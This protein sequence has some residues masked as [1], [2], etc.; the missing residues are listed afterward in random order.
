MLMIGSIPCLA[1]IAFMNADS[2]THCL[3]IMAQQNNPKYIKRDRLRKLRSQ[4]CIIWLCSS[5]AS[6]HTSD[7]LNGHKVFFCMDA[8][9]LVLRGWSAHFHQ[10][11]PVPAAK[12]YGNAFPQGLAIQAT[13]E[14]IAS[15]SVY[16]LKRSET[17]SLLRSLY[18]HLQT[19]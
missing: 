6:H 13:N 4:T 5:H 14:A 8:L 2:N 15:S 17:K 11:L 16:L 19:Y 9:F 1:L 7:P 3:A 12:L 10:L 18:T